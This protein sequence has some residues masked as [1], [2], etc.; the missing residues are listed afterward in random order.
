MNYQDS[1]N[2]NSNG[3]S[4][5]NKRENGTVFSKSKYVCCAHSSTPQDWIANHPF[6]SRHLITNLSSDSSNIFYP[7]NS[8]ELVNL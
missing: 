1:T 8:D 4:V 6:Y 7:N 5:P 2:S 3:G